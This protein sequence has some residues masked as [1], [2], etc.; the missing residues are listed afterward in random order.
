MWP[1]TCDMWHLTCYMWHME[2]G[3]HSLKILGPLL[4]RFG[5]EDVFTIFSQ[6]MTQSMNEWMNNRGVCRTAPALPGLVNI[7]VGR[8]AFLRQVQDY[9]FF[10]FEA[11]SMKNHEKKH[12]DNIGPMLLKI[13]WLVF[14][15]YLVSSLPLTPFH[16]PLIVLPL[17]T[18]H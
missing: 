9:I 1:V 13:A 7:L 2:G 11:P 5:S 8:T 12:T 15:K 3:E 10:Y 17:T 18:Y 16:L 6:I 4:M 14:R